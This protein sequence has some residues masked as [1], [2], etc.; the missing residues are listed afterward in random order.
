MAQQGVYKP[1]FTVEIPAGRDVRILQLTDTQIIDGAQSRPCQAAHDKTTYA[2]PLIKQYCYDYLTEII[3]NTKPD[4]ILVTGDLVY[5]KYDDN[6]S[7]LQAFIA[8]MD[9]FAIPWA[10]IFGNHDN[11]SEMGA[12]WQCQQ[13]ENAKHCLFKRGALTGN[14]NYTVGIQQDDK[15]QRVF[16]MLDSNGCGYAS[17]ASVANGRTK[18]SHGFGQDQIAWYTQEM[19]TLKSCSP[20]TKISFVF[21]IQLAVFADALKKYGFDNEQVEQDIWVNTDRDFGYIGR[22]LKSSWDEDYTIFNGIKALGADSILVGHEHCNSVSVMYDGVR[23]QY[24]QKSSEYDRINFIAQQNQ[25]VASYLYKRVGTPLV[26]GT[27]LLLSQTDGSI[28]NAYIYYCENAG[29]KLDW[30]KILTQN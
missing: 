13:L 24:G 17:P 6:G 9:S 3:Q 4:L 22:K 14:G 11:E 30:E 25:V 8:F 16:V 18:T 5:G 27:V 20:E 15:L 21:H 10:P 23:L 29:G 1:D 28:K 19:R 26:G 7:A 2:T 12:E